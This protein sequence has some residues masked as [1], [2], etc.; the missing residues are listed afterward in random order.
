MSVQNGIV[1]MLLDNDDYL[2]RAGELEEMTLL[3]MIEDVGEKVASEGFKIKPV[4]IE[5]YRE[6]NLKWIYDK[7]TQ[8]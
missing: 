1:Y 4:S 8:P 6:L 5:E 3:E 7:P 2:I